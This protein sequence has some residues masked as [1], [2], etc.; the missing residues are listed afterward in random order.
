ME[1]CRRMPRR[2][3]LFPV[4]L[5][6]LLPAQAWAE[7]AVVVTFPPLAGLVHMLAPELPVESLLAAGADPHHFQLRPRQIDRLRHTSLL[8]RASRDDGGW[9]GLTAPHQL[10]L[11]QRDDHAWLRP[12]LVRAA[13]PGLAAELKRVAPEQSAAIERNLPPALADCD[14]FAAAWAKALAPLRAAGVAMQHPAW[15][16]LFEANG[17]AVHEV[18]ES[19]KHGD[20]TQPH[21][22]EHGI[23]LL[24]SKPGV[25]LIGD[26]R[27][28]NR[29]LEWLKKRAR[30]TPRLIVLDDIGEAGADWRQL[31]QANL[32]RLARP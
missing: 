8:L 7:S 12:Q 11:W 16:K 23:E 29:T 21:Q 9:A 13:L 2:P 19:H 26:L 15:Q 1:P 6:L 20:E 25:V 17:V 4:L 31:M 14:R 10:D 22:L 3:L 24:R 5:L 32:E 27:H 30:P 18:F 28:S